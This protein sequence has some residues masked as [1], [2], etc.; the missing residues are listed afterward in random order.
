MLLC[1]FMRLNFV[2]GTALLELRCL[3]S[4]V[5]SSP[6]LPFLNL[7]YLLKRHSPESFVLAYPLLRNIQEDSI[8]F[9]SSI[10]WNKL[11]LE[12]HIL[13]KRDDAVWSPQIFELNRCWTLFA[14]WSK[15]IHDVQFYFENSIGHLLEIASVQKGEPK[16]QE[17]FFQFLYY[18]SFESFLLEKGLSNLDF[19]ITPYKTDLPHFAVP[20]QKWKCIACNYSIN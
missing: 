9:P 12:C 6:L 14:Y 19:G 16:N 20:L 7:S 1:G 5:K 3:N 10:A 4:V 17:S 18:W 8:C 2:V 13:T 11:I 15:W